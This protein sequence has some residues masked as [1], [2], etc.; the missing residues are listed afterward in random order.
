M[1]KGDDTRALMTARG[2]NALKGASMVYEGIAMIFMALVIKW[3][4]QGERGST[5]IMTFF[6]IAGI[7]AILWGSMWVVR[8][9]DFGNRL[10]TKGDTGPPESPPGHYV[11][12]PDQGTVEEYTPMQPDPQATPLGQQSISSSPYTYPP[13]TYSRDEPGKCPECGGTLFLGRTN[14]PH[15]SAPVNP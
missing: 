14:C 9:D 1:V 11:R 4:T 6:I 12:T 10:G 5:L 7:V 13:R 15:C 2:P 8:Y 3:I